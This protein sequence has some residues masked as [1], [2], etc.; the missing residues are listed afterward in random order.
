MISIFSCSSPCCVALGI[1]SVAG[2][3]ALHCKSRDFT[4]TFLT[5]KQKD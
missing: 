2:L 1:P 3:F 4:S 5:D